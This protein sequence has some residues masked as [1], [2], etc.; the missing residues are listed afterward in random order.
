MG[1]GRRG[2]WG[3]Q[4]SESPAGDDK[5]ILGLLFRVRREA[6]GTL[7]RGRAVPACRAV[8]VAGRPGKGAPGA[9]LG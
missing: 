2:G 4:A 5:D 8:F 6:I 1:T 3:G 7:S 9:G